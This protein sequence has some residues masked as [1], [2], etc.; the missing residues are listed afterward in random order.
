MK[1]MKLS[2]VA[3]CLSLTFVGTA[4]AEGSDA[5]SQ[6]QMRNQGQGQDG[7]A[8]VVLIVPMLT[9]MDQ[10]MAS[11]CWA[12]LYDST[13]LK[14]NMFTI[15]GPVDIP[16]LESG[17]IAGFEWDRNFDSVQ[18]G[19]NATL[20]V[21]Q[22]SDYTEDSTTFRANQRVRDLDARMGFFEDIKSVKVSCANPSRSGGSGSSGSGSTR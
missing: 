5:G 8:P 18:V 3:C 19:P 4:L 16:S 1:I 15:S 21:W 9:A 10:G 17:R 11:G 22:G 6:D 2:A 20:M 14:G 7:K 13:D 12:R